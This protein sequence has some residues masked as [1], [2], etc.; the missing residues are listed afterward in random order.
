LPVCEGWPDHVHY[1]LG[2]YRFVDVSMS[3]MRSLA[4]WTGR[5]G[6][7]LLMLLAAVRL[8]AATPAIAATA[9]TASAAPAAQHTRE[10][11][12]LSYNVKSLPMLGGADRQ[13]QIGRLLARRRAR[14]EEPQVVLLQEAFS[15]DAEAI[16]KRA[17]Y[18]FDATSGTP[19]VMFSNPSGLEILSDHPIVAQYGRSFDDCAGA[20]C[21]ARKSVL[22]V[23]LQIPGMPVPLRVFNTHLQAHEVNESVRK[24][25]IDDIDIFLRRIGFGPEPAIFGGDLNF[26]PRDRSYRKFLRSLSFFTETGRYCLDVSTCRIAVGDD[27][28]TDLNDVW[29][30]SHDRQYFYAPKGSHVRIEPV[31]LTRNFTEPYEGQPLSDHWGYEVRYRISW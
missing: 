23:T 28:R 29:K 22:G 8:E 17:G 7:T 6:L 27:G 30:T 20:D 26:Q 24:N 31:G 12:V 25:Q 21:L 18:R 1:T 5:G 9:A 15:E 11:V 19:S 16:R 4:L 10:L 2:H 14:G 13:R 3:A